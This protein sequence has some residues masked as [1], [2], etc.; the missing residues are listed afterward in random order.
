MTR[1]RLVARY[2]ILLA[3]VPGVVMALL[4]WLGALGG[5][6]RAA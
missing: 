1:L 5:R 4:T 3:A 6:E 2:D